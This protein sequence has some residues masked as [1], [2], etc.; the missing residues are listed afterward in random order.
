MRQEK[1]AKEE[2]T[3]DKIEQ[4]LWQAADILRGAVRPE[5]YGSYML[6]LLFFKRLSDVY[7]EEYQELLEK[8]QDEEIA[9]QKF[10]RF[11]IPEG[12]LWMDIRVVAQ[13]VGQKLNDTF[14]Q[15]A[16]I[17]PSLE[18][19]I[20]RADFNKQDELPQDRLIRLFEHFSR[21]QL[22]NNNVSPDILGTIYEY[23]LKKF[24]EVA[25]QRADTHSDAVLYAKLLLY[26]GA[27]KYY[28]KSIS[29]V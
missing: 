6:P 14:A 18:G 29:S 16:K 20:N 15:I 23:L 24:N 1:I 5:R 28:S 21:L 9:K 10:H 7:E 27:A 3:L 19:V 25:P 22:G 13:N 11:T 26:S 4:V 17:N 8:F 12:C 2:L